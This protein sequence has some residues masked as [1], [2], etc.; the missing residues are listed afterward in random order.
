M[1]ATTHIIP[2]CCIVYYLVT[3]SI[4]KIYN[5][6][7]LCSSAS[8]SLYV[9]VPWLSQ[10]YSE[11][12]HPCEATGS[13]LSP[14]VWGGS[15]PCPAPPLP[16][17]GECALPPQW[18]HQPGR[19]VL[20]LPGCRLGWQPVLHLANQ[21]LY[22]TCKLLLETG[23]DQQSFL[24]LSLSLFILAFSLLMHT[25]THKYIFFAFYVCFSEGLPHFSSG[26]F[27][28]WG[29]DTFIALRGLMLVTGRHLEARSVWQSLLHSSGC[30]LGD[31]HG[32]ICRWCLF[33]LLTSYSAK[34]PL[35]CLFYHVAYLL[36]GCWMSL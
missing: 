5:H 7:R 2:F 16:Q 15:P 24:S 26:I 17:P 9:I 22:S 19:A 30:C 29:R 8:V 14:D 18:C 25:H 28:C 10:I 4:L 35:V 1:I 31:P 33:W 6:W 34:C 11:W 21:C 23:K 36:N 32:W 20:C 12:I 27:R 3:S 13:G